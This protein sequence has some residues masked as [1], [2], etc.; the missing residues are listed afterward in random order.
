MLP[1]EFCA[2]AA[3]RQEQGLQASGDVGGAIERLLTPTRPCAPR[4]LAGTIKHNQRR[5]GHGSVPD[6]VTTGRHTRRSAD[7]YRTQVVIAH[8]WR[9][10][11]IPHLVAFLLSELQPERELFSCHQRRRRLVE[12]VHPCPQVAESAKNARIFSRRSKPPNKASRSQTTRV[13]DSDST[14]ASATSVW[15]SISEMTHPLTLQGSKPQAR[16]RASDHAMSLA[17]SHLVEAP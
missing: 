3:R 16:V 6:P 13:G 15:S 7:R 1:P 11:V 2:P 12:T 17:R 5:L 14:S 4:R 10:C 8:R 9:S